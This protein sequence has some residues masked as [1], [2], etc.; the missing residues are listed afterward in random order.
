MRR[1][2]QNK[3]EDLQVGK[4]VQYGLS[5]FDRTKIDYKNLT[6]M[7]EAY[8]KVAW[9]TPNRKS[10][11]AWPHGTRMGLGARG[12]LRTPPA[13]RPLAKLPFG[14]CVIDVQ[15]TGA[16]RSCNHKQLTKIVT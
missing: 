5:E 1:R 9:R 14:I 8:S 3:H 16:Q 11:N 15:C 6:A 12:A 7:V 4:A 13:A 10:P 2:A